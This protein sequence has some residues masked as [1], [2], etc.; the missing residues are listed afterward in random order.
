MV[1][2]MAPY[3]SLFVGQAGSETAGNHVSGNAL[4]PL[5]RP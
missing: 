5:T 2:E 4:R 1:G 3:R